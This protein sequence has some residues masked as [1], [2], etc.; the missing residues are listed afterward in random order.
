[1]SLTTLTFR[2][3]RG[4]EV[5]ERLCDDTW[6]PL[7]SLKALRH[8][9]IDMYDIGE[10]NDDWLAEGALAWPHIRTLDISAYGQLFTLKGLVPLLIHCPHIRKLKVHPSVLPFDLSLLPSDGSAA[11]HNI[12]GTLSLH[13]AKSTDV[14]PP[15]VFAC[16]KAMFPNVTDIERADENFHSDYAEYWEQYPE[17]RQNFDEKWDELLELFEGG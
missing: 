4:Y 16:I 1:M 7:L 15:A 9:I 12:K 6:Q 17:D 14:N 3:K 2:D 10:L 13:K 8:L 5:L 11:N